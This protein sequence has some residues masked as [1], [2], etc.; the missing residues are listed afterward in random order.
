MIREAADRI[1]DSIYLLAV[2]VFRR[3]LRLHR[4]A[5]LPQ[6][7]KSADDRRLQGTRRAQQ[8]PAAQPGGKEARRHLRLGGKPRAGRRLSRHA[9]RHSQHH[10]HAHHHAPGQGGGHAKLWRQRNPLRRQLRRGL[11]TRPEAR[12]AS[13]ARSFCT[14]STT[15]P[16]SPGRAPSASSCSSSAR[17]WKLSS[18]RLA[19]AD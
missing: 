7:R 18:C 5:G 1:R 13:R 17:N 3:A 14:P 12:R 10:R 6:A 19:A 9:A 8:N 16:S 11:R 15:S 4:P 2:P